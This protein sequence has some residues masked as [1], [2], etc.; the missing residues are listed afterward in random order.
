MKTETPDFR[1]LQKSNLLINSGMHWYQRGTTSEIMAAGSNNK[2]V[3]DRFRVQTGS[4]TGTIRFERDL[5][6]KPNVG[7]WSALK[8]TVTAAGAT[9]GGATAFIRQAIEGF[10]ANVLRYSDFV[11]SFYVKSNTTGAYTMALTSAF[12]GTGASYLARFTIDAP[13][14]GRG[15]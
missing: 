15:K 1:T 13:T 8:A 5:T 7:E 14:C 4:G 9:S 3:P 12:G 6:D 10:V 11:V 2:F